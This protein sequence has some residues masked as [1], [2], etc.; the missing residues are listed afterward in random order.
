MVLWSTH[1]LTKMSTRNV[2]WGEKAVGA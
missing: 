2:S 1:R